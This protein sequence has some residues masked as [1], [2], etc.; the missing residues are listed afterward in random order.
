VEG[1]QKVCQKVLYY[2]NLKRLF[3]FLLDRHFRKLLQVFALNA[4]KC[5]DELQ[6]FANT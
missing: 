3:R 4:K 2:F 1:L 6:D 5:L